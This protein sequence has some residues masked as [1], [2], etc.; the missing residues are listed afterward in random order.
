[1]KKMKKNEKMA[2]RHRSFLVCLKLC[3]CKKCKKN[4]ISQQCRANFG[5]ITRAQIARDNLALVAR[6]SR[7]NLELLVTEN[8]ANVA[9]I[10]SENLAGHILNWAVYYVVYKIFIFLIQK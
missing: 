7:A 8:L 4:Y 2:G 6:K 3:V 1:M 10:A 5:L 9:P